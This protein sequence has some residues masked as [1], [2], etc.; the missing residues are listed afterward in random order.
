MPSPS[1]ACKYGYDSRQPEI[2]AYR[3]ALKQCA[4]AAEGIA[5]MAARGE[6]A[7]PV[8]CMLAESYAAARAVL[9]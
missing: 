8:E 4:E 1:D 7:D 5:A 3:E 2:D 6:I 9:E